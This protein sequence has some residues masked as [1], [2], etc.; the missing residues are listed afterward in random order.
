MK[1]LLQ[2]NL[3]NV[4]FFC[5]FAVATVLYTIEG[6]WARSAGCLLLSFSNALPL[7]I[8]WQ[9]RQ[10]TPTWTAIMNGSSILGLVLVM[11]GWLGFL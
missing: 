8:S 9:Q 11:L 7:W 3:V 1:K 4:L 5:I 10:P 2:E 6:A